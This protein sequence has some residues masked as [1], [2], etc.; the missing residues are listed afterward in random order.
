MDVL[1]TK[2]PSTNSSIAQ[3]AYVKAY[4][5]SFNLIRVLL[6][7]RE[8]TN[9]YRRLS[10]VPDLTYVPLARVERARL[11]GVDAEP[12]IRRLSSDDDYIYITWP[13]PDG[14][15]TSASPAHQHGFSIP[16]GTPEEV[17][18]RMSEALELPGQASDY[19]FSIQHA[20]EHLWRQRKTTPT[21]YNQIEKLC[22]LDIELLESR[23]EEIY[24]GT[25]IGVR[26]FTTLA[27]MYENEGRLR[28][29]STILERGKV[30]GQYVKDGRIEQIQIVLGSIA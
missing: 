29:A 15:S 5:I 8:T 20:L 24:E 30:I 14:G 4:M 13:T 2:N 16:D 19:H 12:E 25:V 28:D 10:D 7:M 17:L 21:L 1:Y 18:Q 11:W 6:V 26:A 22:L 23:T 3:Q 27:G 9:W